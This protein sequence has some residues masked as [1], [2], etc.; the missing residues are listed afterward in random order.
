MNIFIKDILSIQPSQ[1][2]INKEKLGRVNKYLDSVNIEDINPL[3]IK[4]IGNNI[5]FTDGHTRAYALYKR[6]IRKIKVYWDKDD[7]DWDFYL[8]CVCLCK[9]EKIYSIK[10]LEDKIVDP[11]DYFEL[12]IKRCEKMYDD[13]K[14]SSN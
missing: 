7:L 6:G 8:N 10:D 12:W 5:F 4:K 2:Y 13:L 14:A 3:P 11:E 9:E 1:L